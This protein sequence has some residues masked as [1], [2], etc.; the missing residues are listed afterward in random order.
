M[1]L[2]A[3][4]WICGIRVKKMFKLLSLVVNIGRCKFYDIDNFSLIDQ[5]KKRR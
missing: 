4:F 5:L 2:Y 3:T 1:R